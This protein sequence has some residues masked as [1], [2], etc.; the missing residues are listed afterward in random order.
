VTDP[1]QELC[2]GFARRV[3]LSLPACAL[4]LN[5]G[6]ADDGTLKSNGMECR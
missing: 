4:F 3:V 5:C 2:A 6:D 1:A